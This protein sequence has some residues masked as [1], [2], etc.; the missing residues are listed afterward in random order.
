MWITPNTAERPDVIRTTR[1]TR[2]GSGRPK[3]RASWPCAIPAVTRSTCWTTSSAL[4]FAFEPSADFAAIDGF[5]A[6]YTGYGGEDTDFAMRVQ[7]AG[8]SLWWVGGAD[9]FHQHHDSEVVRMRRRPSV[10]RT[11]SGSPT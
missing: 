2:G 11:S 1:N 8:G 4:A 3:R 9:A 5:D 10:T 7:E 6:G